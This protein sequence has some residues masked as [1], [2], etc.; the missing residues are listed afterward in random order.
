MADPKSHLAAQTVGAKAGGDL[1]ATLQLSAPV[2]RHGNTST[3]VAPT[4]GVQAPRG[5]D[6]GS[7]LQQHI[8]CDASDPCPPVALECLLTPV[9]AW[10][11]YGTVKCCFRCCLQA[12][13]R[14][15]AL[16]GNYFF[17]RAGLPARS[18]VMAQRHGL[19]GLD[20]VL[21]GHNDGLK[22]SDMAV[23]YDHRKNLW[24]D[25]NVVHNRTPPDPVVSIPGDGLTVELPQAVLLGQR[26]GL[27]VSQNPDRFAALHEFG[28]KV[29][30]LLRSLNRTMFN[31]LVETDHGFPG[32]G[33]DG[34]RL[35][36]L[37]E[38]PELAN[39][40][41]SNPTLV[42]HPKV[43][44]YPRAT[45]NSVLLAKELNGPEALT[46]SRPTILPTPSAI[47]GSHSQI[48]VHMLA[49]RF[50]P[51]ETRHGSVPAPTLSNDWRV[52]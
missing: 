4:S 51:A 14:S 25:D 3:P 28:R 47:P 45:Y 44:A 5:L 36:Q 13:V 12:A 15:L 38:L 19:S 16:Q 35:R 41:V 37:L 9:P 33:P 32:T 48:Q 43:H 34:Q 20:E 49:A 29:V 50:A 11:P 7:C 26:P 17:W 22:F 10:T 6:V 46:R 40:Y 2:G 39:V 42:G 1:D 23:W 21:L 30:P 52:Q 27:F 31:L 24:T 8:P 18:K